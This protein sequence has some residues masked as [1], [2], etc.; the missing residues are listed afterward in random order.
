MPMM[1]ISNCS[2]TLV[3]DPKF[4]ECLQKPPIKTPPPNFY[5]AVTFARLP[6]KPLPQ[7]GTS[8]LPTLLLKT[9]G[10][11]IFFEAITN[12]ARTTLRMQRLL[13][14]EAV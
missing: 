4:S 8:Y 5:V 6:R 14:G 7:S 9:T 1:T 12:Q 3:F 10:D 11:K 13:K 2:R